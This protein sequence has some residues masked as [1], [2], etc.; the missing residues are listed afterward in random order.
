MND[1]YD[2]RIGGAVALSYTALVL[3]NIY[4]VVAPEFGLSREVV[5]LGIKIVML[6]VFIKCIPIILKRVSIGH[7]GFCL[8]AVST[9]CLNIL[10]FPQ[11][12]QYFISTMIDF[13]SMPNIV[14]ILLLSCRNYKCLISM[15]SVCS[16]ISSGLV[17]FIDIFYLSNINSSNYRLSYFMGLSN[18][19]IL[20]TILLMYDLISK[21]AVM[22]MA[23]DVFLI[24]GNMIFILIKGSR[25]ALLAIVIGCII[26]FFK[27]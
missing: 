17:L 26:I 14:T 24:L 3:I 5:S 6:W 13:I 12:N 20:P 11:T 2:K 18:A 25:G 23:I 7:I 16:K 15:L 27:N 10:L 8:V 9:C 19:L 1:R 21:K 4:N 22:K